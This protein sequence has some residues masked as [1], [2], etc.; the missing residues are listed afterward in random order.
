MGGNTTSFVI[1]AVLLVILGW[2]AA[3]AE[4]GISRVSRFR[5]EE[6]VR[7][8]RR[9]SARLLAMA[10][11]PIRYLNL[12]T[13]IRVG[14]EMAAAVLVTVV[15]VRGFHSTWV[16]VLVAIGV[17]VLVSFVMVGV[18]PRTIGRQHPL[19]TAT[20]A[21]VLL[22]PLARVLGP[23]PKL[24]I[25]LGNALTP[26]K[27]FREGPF[28]SEA[29]L[30]A[31]VD[32]AEK[33]SLIEDEERRMVH[34]V[35]ELGDTIVREV[36]V[37]RTDLVLIE[38]HKTVRQA[39]TLALR[40]GFSRI[41]VVGENED[42]VVGIVYLKDLV[43]R[44]HINR[45]AE[46]E[47]VSSVLRPAVFVPDS[48]PAGDL[49]RE[50]Q[51]RRSHV[52]IVIDE[53]GGTA[54]LVTIEDILEEIVGEI[55]DEYDREAPPVEELGDGSYRVTARLPVDELGELFG[56][57]LADEDVDTVGGLLAKHLGRVPIPGAACEVP[58]P[59]DDALPIVAL[60]LTAESSAGRRNRIDTVLAEPV[61]RDHGRRDE[62][63]TAAHGDAEAP[64]ADASRTE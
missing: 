38:R 64:P 11:D 15:C 16:A 1:G 31:L 46:S 5:A 17:M 2:L 23:I 37:P 43:R 35:F 22:L 34:S 10:S 59:E 19:N 30:R 28:A 32:L 61:A 3:C 8:G 12:A 21:S 48:K 13:L 45:D 33:D 6:A 51:Q 41:P 55:T 14:S 24:L 60:R 40:S 9:G 29:E 49:L 62:A 50:M 57:E 52:A 58:L 47:P 63:A 39:L 26:G 18:S 53:Y 27:G 36:M 4:A 56:L 25:L 42:D 7:A 20:A 44:T 54:G